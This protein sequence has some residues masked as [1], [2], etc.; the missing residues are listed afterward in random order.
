VG[1]IISDGSGTIAL[2]KAGTGTLTLSG[3]NTYSQATTVNGGTLAVATGGQIA[4]AGGGFVVGSTA[5]TNA[6]LAITGGSVSDS[7]TT[8]NAWASTLNA[9]YG[10]NGS[11][12]VTLTSG[13]LAAQ[14]QLFIGNSNGS[15]NGAFAAMTMTGGTLNVGSYF[16]IGFN[17]NTSG[18]FSQSGGVVTQSQTS[19]AGATILG[20]GAGA[21][22]MANLSGGT[23]NASA[24]GIYVAENGAGTGILDISGSASVTAG[25]VGVRF[26]NDSSASTGIV[27]LLGGTLTTKHRAAGQRQWD[28]DIQLQ[29]RHPEA[30]RRQRHLP[31]RTDQRLCLWRGRHDP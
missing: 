6:A 28:G 14:R 1:G 26:G 21:F 3:A 15:A 7:T 10:A 4:N 18:V 17:T 23:F 5:N 13:T 29:R 24:G 9:G 31:D 20:S 16:G 8:G 12:F 22:G 30:E 19:G 2:T 11:G 25:N 27:N